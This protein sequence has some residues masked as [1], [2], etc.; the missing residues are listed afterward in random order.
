MIATRKNKIPFQMMILVETEFKDDIVF[1][2][3]RIPIFVTHERFDR[4][5]A[6]ELALADHLEKLWKEELKEQE[7]RK[8]TKNYVC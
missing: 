1:M 2:P 3:F 7:W 5:V 8:A 4:Q 6:V